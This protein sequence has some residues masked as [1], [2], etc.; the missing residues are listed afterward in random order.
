M[1]PRVRW[2]WYCGRHLH[3]NHHVEDVFDGAMRIVHKD[4]AK[5]LRGEPAAPVLRDDELLE[6]DA[7][8]VRCLDCGF[9]SNVPRVI[10][11]HDFGHTE[12]K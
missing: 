9:T 11:R 4:C 3:G 6:E 12:E 10:D 7:K 5:L 2:C 1:T 8:L